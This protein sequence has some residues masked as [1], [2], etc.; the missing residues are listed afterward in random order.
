MDKKKDYYFHRPVMLKEVVRFLN[1]QPV[2][3]YVDG[4]LGGGGHTE[5]IAVKLGEKGRIIGIDQDKDA[6][7]AAKKRLASCGKK[8]VFI[9][10]NFKNLEKILE[11]ISI[12]KIDGIL[13]DL[14][15]SSYQFDNPMRGFSFKN[16]SSNI[17]DMRMDRQ[18]RLSALE[19]VNQYSEQDLRKIFF[20]Y[21]EEP[22]SRQ[23]ARNIIIRRR[24]KQ[25]KTVEEL[26]DVIKGATPPKYRY[27]RRRH[28]ATKIF[29][30]LRIEVNQELEALRQVLPQAVS[31]LKKGGRLVVISFHS[32]EDRIVKH[33]FRENKDKGAVDILTKKPIMPTQEEIALN[34]RATSAKMRVIQKI[35]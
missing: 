25:I 14:G 7:E 21:G 22:F 17:L 30:A 11:N 27:S 31:R 12:D 20:E 19:V 18:Q 13:L 26:L 34:P 10:D 23:V 4:T 24:A 9:H 28:F 1:P 3:I 2:G 16:N 5:R 32:L 6:L 8:I 29:Q 35:E 33:F 15:V